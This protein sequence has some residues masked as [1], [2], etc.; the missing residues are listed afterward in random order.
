MD[1]AS[2]LSDIGTERALF[3]LGAVITGV[4][5]ILVFLS[6]NDDQGALFGVFSIYLG[7][8]ATPAIRNSVPDYKRT[9]AI[10]LGGVGVIAILMG[11][12]SGLP[13]LFVIGA[14]AALMNLF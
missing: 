1:V 10:A 12:Q 13:V 2:R 3:A 11:T 9:G 14:I 7:G 4:L 6:G 5:T 8:A